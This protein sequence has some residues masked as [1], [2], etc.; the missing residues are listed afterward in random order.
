MSNAFGLVPYLSLFGQR[1][2]VTVWGFVLGKCGADAGLWRYGFGTRFQIIF[3]T[4]LR[5]AWR[6]LAL[7]I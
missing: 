3:D 7:R 4:I 6:I 5:N 1:Q 2:R